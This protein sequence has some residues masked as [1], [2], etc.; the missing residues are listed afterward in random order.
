MVD[1]E[2]RDQG[3][4]GDAN[5]HG[6]GRGDGGAPVLAPAHVIER[7]GGG[8]EEGA[9]RED[10]GQVDGVGEDRERPAGKLRRRHVAP[11]EQDQLGEEQ[12]GDQLADGAHH[13][14]GEDGVG[15]HETGD[16]DE[17]WIAREVRPEV[18]GGADRQVE[19]P[20]RITPLGD[21]REGGSIPEGEG[22]EE[23]RPGGQARPGP[24]NPHGQHRHQQP[25]QLAGDEG[26]KGDAQHAAL[27]SG[28]LPG[29]GE[30]GRHLPRVYRSPWA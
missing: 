9:L 30:R 27:A 25:D 2:R 18:A 29:A 26:G 23:R 11:L 4:T 28:A 5:Q 13:D 1:D 3:D 19:R 15:H 6:D 8:G 22:L 24:A 20:T 21:L 7:G 14:A 12:Q 17:Q 10:C 16:V